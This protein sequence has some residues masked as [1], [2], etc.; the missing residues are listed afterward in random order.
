M[1][2]NKMSYK[3]VSSSYYEIFINSI[4]ITLKN[5]MYDYF[6]IFYI[7]IISFVHNLFHIYFN[8]IK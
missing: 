2:I 5:I 7:T 3:L 6:Q 8:K 4:F 1:N